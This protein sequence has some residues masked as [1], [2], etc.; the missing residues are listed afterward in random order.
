MADKP[1]RRDFLSTATKLVGGICVVGAAWPIL[2][3]L[4]P[5]ASERALF[6]EELSVGDLAPGAETLLQ[7]DIGPCYLRHLTQTEIVEARRVDLLTLSDSQARN[8]NLFSPGTATVEN[9]LLHPSRKLILVSAQCPRQ[10]CVVRGNQSGD[11]GGWFC[12]CDQSHFD[13]LGR[14][15]RGAAPQNLAIPRAR[16]EG[17]TLVVERRLA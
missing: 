4:G 16:L 10:G 3:S 1:I 11:F 7:L 8:A 15:R 17:D 14:I 2:S 13:A 9:R 12:S 5:D 6:P